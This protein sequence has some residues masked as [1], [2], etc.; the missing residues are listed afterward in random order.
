MEDLPTDTEAKVIRFACGAIFGFFSSA[1][2]CYLF[3]AIRRDSPTIAWF[4]IALGTYFSGYWAMK[5]G[6]YFWK[7]IVNRWRFW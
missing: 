1:V 7:K 3:L 6:D 4:L 5:Y 2:A